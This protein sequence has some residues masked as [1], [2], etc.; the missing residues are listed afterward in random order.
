MLV[1]TELEPSPTDW[2]P[3]VHGDRFG[4]HGDRFGVHGERAV[5]HGKEM[6]AQAIDS[7]F[8]EFESVGVSVAGDAM[9]SILERS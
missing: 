8:T 2:I 4:V 5:L 1:H 6:G 9:V 7:A 3:C